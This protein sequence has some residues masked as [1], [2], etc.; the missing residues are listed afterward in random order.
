MKWNIWTTNLVF[1]FSECEFPLER[2]GDGICD[3]EAGNQKCDFDAGDCIDEN[4]I[5]WLSVDLNG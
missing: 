4:G 2:I 5:L 3:Y 1:L